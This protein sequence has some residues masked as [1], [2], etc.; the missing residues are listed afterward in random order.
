MSPGE[1][2]E[3]RL[4]DLEAMVFGIR[5]EGGLG[6]QLAALRQDFSAWRR[7]DRTRRE[8]ETKEKALAQ[9]AILLTLGT[10]LIS[11]LAVIVVLIGMVVAR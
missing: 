11:L 2:V 9:R 8:T 7:E 4:A 3:K 1:R 6:D 10:G 5:G